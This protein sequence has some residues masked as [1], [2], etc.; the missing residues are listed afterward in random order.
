MAM[1]TVPWFIGG[2]AEHSPAVARMLAYAATNGATG[3]ISP[4]DLKVTALPTPGAAVRIMPGGAAIVSLYPGAANQSYTVRNATA[5]D[6]QV[7]ATTSSGA[8]VRYLILRIDD[9]EYGGQVPA[10]VRFG[11]YV[12][13][14][15][16]SS[17]TNLA[18]PFV[19]L[20]RIN[21]P[22]S[23]ATITQAMIT[24]LRVV[25]NPRRSS[26]VLMTNPT[27]EKTMTT[28]VGDYYPDFRP[29]VAVPAWATEVS[30]VATI[31]SIAAAAGDTYGEMAVTL[32]PKGA[33]QFRSMNAFYDVDQGGSAEERHTFTI[34]GKGLIPAA[35]RG[36]S[37]VLGT[38]FRRIDGP[39]HLVTKRGT[40]VVF[41][42]TF[43]EAAA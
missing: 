21:Q 23:T 25:A 13:P 35:L 36:T 7:P 30:I 8:A 16:V 18:Y 28:S 33:S 9:P 32:G 5:T 42:I 4:G 20:A 6:V 22:A 12:R 24:D 15:L 2:G 43:Y 1:D 19:A 14:V 29:T 11:P 38:E 3:V 27:P 39:G 34:G 31:S 37:Q 41:Q 26:D 40:H 10:D 17:I